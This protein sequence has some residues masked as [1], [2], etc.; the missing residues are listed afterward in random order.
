MGMIDTIVASR[1]RIFVGTYFSTFSG[2]INR[3]RGYHGMTMKKSYY[4]VEDRKFATH[5]W[6]KNQEGQIFAKEWP[7][8]WVGIDGD[9]L[10]SRE[11]F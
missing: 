7:T 10:V 1:G 11:V 4:G 2:Y 6:D 5:T 3:M 8:G 9:T